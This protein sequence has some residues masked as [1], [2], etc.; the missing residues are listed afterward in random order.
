MSVYVEN[1]KELT[2]LEP[3]SDYNKV[4]GYRVNI[5]SFIALLYNSNEQVAFEMKNNPICI[6]ISKSY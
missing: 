1:P 5:H 4:A 3:V 6:S 2:K